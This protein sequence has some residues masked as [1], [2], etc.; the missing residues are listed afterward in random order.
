MMQP[1]AVMMLPERIKPSCTAAPSVAPPARASKMADDHGERR[2][3]V[4]NDRSGANQQMPE[5]VHIQQET[6]IH[7]SPPS[8]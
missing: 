5:G 1:A 6:P 7:S 3:S 4:T 8:W 2:R